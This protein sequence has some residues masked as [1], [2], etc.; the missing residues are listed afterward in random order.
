MTK[1]LPKVVELHY[2][3]PWQASLEN[4]TMRTQD[5]FDCLNLLS[6]GTM[7]AS[8]YIENVA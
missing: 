7:S 2:P 5:V 3:L 6:L 8:A 4:F 1:I